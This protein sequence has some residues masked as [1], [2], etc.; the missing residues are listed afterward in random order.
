MESYKRLSAYLRPYWWIIIIATLF[1]LVTSGLSGAIA[2]FVKPVLDGTLNRD[3]E[4]I[5]VFLQIGRAHV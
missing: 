1:S 2:W 3:A 4:A 5:K